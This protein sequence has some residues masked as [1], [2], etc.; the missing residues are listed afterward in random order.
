[1]PDAFGGTFPAPYLP[2]MTG[3]AS[4]GGTVTCTGSW[5]PA[6][7]LARSVARNQD[8]DR[9]PF[10]YFEPGRTRFVVAI[11][12]FGDPPASQTKTLRVVVPRSSRR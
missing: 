1:M 11:A 10:A 6:T 12:A 3:P 5:E 9:F 7:T 2:A 4:Y 8:P